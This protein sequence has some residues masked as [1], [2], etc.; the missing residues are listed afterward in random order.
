MGNFCKKCITFAV[1][2]VGIFLMFSG[3]SAQAVKT[4]NK[5][6]IESVPW[7]RNVEAFRTKNYAQ[8]QQKNTEYGVLIKGKN[9]NVIIDTTKR[10]LAYEATQKALPEEL[11]KTNN[12]PANSGFVDFTNFIKYHINGACAKVLGSKLIYYGF[13]VLVLLILLKSFFK[14]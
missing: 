8:C 13:L 6:L 2:F 3:V 1:V 5:S 4:Q 10:D 12:Q 14:K 11:R 7:L 9:L